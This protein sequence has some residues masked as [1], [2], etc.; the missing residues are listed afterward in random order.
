MLETSQQPVRVQ[1]VNSFMFT[2]SIPITLLQILTISF[3]VLKVDGVIVPLWI[4]SDRK[5]IR[6]RISK[7]RHNIFLSGGKVKQNHS[8]DSRTLT[9]ISTSDHHVLRRRRAFKDG[10]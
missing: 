8:K 3:Q 4:W 1:D 10:A 6:L 7:D 2:A 5:Q 9:I